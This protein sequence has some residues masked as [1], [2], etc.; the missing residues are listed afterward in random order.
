MAKTRNKDFFSTLRTAG[1]RKR[2]A[3]ALSDLEG[4]GRSAGGRAE[5]VARQAIDDLRKAADSIEK[6]LDIGGAGTR[7]TAARKAANTR[8]RAAAKRS[9]AAKKGARTRA[10]SSSSRS[11]SSRTGTTARK[12]ASGA[13]KTAS[14]AAG[15]ARKTASRTTRSTKRRATKRS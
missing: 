7:A 13:R 12:T 6:R 11:T 14:R 10:R 8:K 1:L 2:V 4:S 3:R 9:S 15:A 5:K